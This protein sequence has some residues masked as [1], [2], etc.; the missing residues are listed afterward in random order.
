MN[1]HFL[2]LTVM[3]VMVLLSGCSSKAPANKVPT[4]AEQK[5]GFTTTTGTLRMRTKNTGTLQAS[6]GSIAIESYT[7]DFT[8]YDGK[9]VIVTGKYSGDTL[10]VSEIKTP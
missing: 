7:V 3:I 4:T 1:K 9:A 6:S 8:A 10:F 2:Y 5:S